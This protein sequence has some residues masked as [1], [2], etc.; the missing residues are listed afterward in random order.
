VEFDG[1]ISLQRCIYHDKKKQ[2]RSVR[3]NACRNL[4]YIR[5]V[6]KLPR[7]IQVILTRFTYFH[8]TL[9]NYEI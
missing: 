7:K 9:T 3:N 5:H 6:N 4:V 1:H 2:S 8:I